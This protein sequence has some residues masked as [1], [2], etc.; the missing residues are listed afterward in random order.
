VGIEPSETPP[1][2]IPESEPAAQTAVAHSRRTAL[3]TVQILL[4]QALLV[5]TG[6]VIAG[7]LTRRLGPELY[8]LLIVA[9]TIVLWVELSTHQL[10]GR[11]TIKFV[12]EAEDWRPVASALV[13]TQFLISM[14]TGVLLAATAPLLARWLQAPEL[15]KYLRLFAIDLPIYGLAAILQSIMIGRGSYGQRAIAIA[16]RWLTRLLLTLLLVGLGLSLTGAI[17]ASVGA[18]VVQLVLAR[19]LVGPGMADRAVLPIRRFAGYALPLFLYGVGMLL[20]QYL[21]L[22]MVQALSGDPSAAGYYGAA[23]NVAII[24]GLLSVAFAP[25]LLAT[26]TKVLRQRQDST[27]RSMIQQGMR[28]VLCLL[29]FAGLVAG[30]APEIVSLVYG[31]AFLPAAPLLAVLFLGAIG[32]T[33]MS[34]TTGILTALHQP[35]QALV[36]TWPLVPLALA[37]GLVLMPRYEAEGIAAGMTALAWLGAGLTVWGV[38]RHSGVLPALGTVLRTLLMAV[39][40]FVLSSVW[41]TVGLWSIVELVTMTL[42]IVAGLF[43]LGE[44]T[45]RDVAFARSLLRRQPGVTRAP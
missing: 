17:L 3:G 14:A 20:F 38:Y 13:R 39:I 26:V 31:Q 27:A 12:A 22:W 29:P 42:L 18:S 8:G 28:L 15:T 5:P 2:G 16:A 43:L 21:D 37:A 25:L 45:G 44:L 11:A 10:M 23:K 6:I 4:A 24:P 1:G 7:F 40:A 19:Y 41:A 33:M 34:V 9:S 36:L 35:R 32:L 30:T